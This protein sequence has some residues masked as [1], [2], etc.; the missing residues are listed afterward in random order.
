MAGFLFR[1][2]IHPTFPGGNFANKSL[3]QDGSFM[4]STNF[5]KSLW[6]PDIQV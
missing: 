5:V 6:L 2:S 4:G 1:Y 3:F